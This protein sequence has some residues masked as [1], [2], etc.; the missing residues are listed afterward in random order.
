[1]RGCL[2]I[3]LAGMAVLVGVVWFVGPPLAGAAVEATL[4]SGGLDADEMDVLVESEPPLR[5]AIGQ[6]DRVTIEAAGVEWNN[7]RAG[8][9]TVELRDVDLVNRTVR[10]AD[11]RLDDVELEQTDDEGDPLFFAVVFSGPSDEAVTAVSIDRRTAE[12][13]AIAAFEAELDVRPDGASLVAP[14]TIRFTS[15]DQVVSGRLEVTAAGELQATTPLG[16]VT[17]VESVGLPL[18]LTD[19]SVGPSGL[20][21]TGTLDVSSLLD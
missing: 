12:R 7:V 11:G 17:V 18:E 14:D 20:E 2:F 8:T 15:G 10:T 5:L 16:I 9:M 13:L 4:T 6:A 21:L 19:V 3:L 1:M